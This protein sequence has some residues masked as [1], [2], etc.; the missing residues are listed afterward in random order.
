MSVFSSYEYCW[1]AGAGAAKVG[2][3]WSPPEL[4]LE[5]LAS[6]PDESHS[7]SYSSSS[8]SLITG[9]AEDA[10]PELAPLG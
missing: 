2:N 8:S 4:W 10:A 9:C 3:S 1:A 6:R 5:A 7:G